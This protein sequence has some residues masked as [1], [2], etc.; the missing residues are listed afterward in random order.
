[1]TFEGQDR[2]SEHYRPAIDGLRAIA[3]IAVMIVHARPGLLPGG[4]AGV[5][6]FFVISGYLITRIV[7]REHAEAR[8]TLA[9]FYLNR[10]KRILPALSVVLAASLAG[11]VL[12]CD[13]AQARALG[14]NLAA[15][16]VFAGNIYSWLE[17]GGYFSIG[18]A[19]MP[20]AHLW[21]LAVEEQF[22]LLYPLLLLALVRLFPR[23]LWLV[24]TV[25]AASSLG[26]AEY[27]NDR[28]PAVAYYLLPT[29]AWELL[30]GYVL[31]TIE[32][33]GRKRS[34]PG[35][36]LGLILVASAFFLLDA[37]TPFPGLAGAP[38]VAET[39]MLIRWAT[40]ETLVGKALASAPLRGLGLL[41][42]SAFL[43]HQPLL[44][45]ARIYPMNAT[46]A[47]VELA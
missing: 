43:W 39:V 38:L 30:G 13:P 26:L 8:F 16:S 23:R 12:L 15:A 44:A 4:F 11:A 22:Y 36:V 5:D 2:R 41:S 46:P 35:A 40:P 24:L 34:Q 1:M 14:R 17:G 42:Y 32:A 28:M 6:I 33:N 7:L 19:Q 20:L 25:G 45:F 9:G 10:A 47:W 3:V 29:R 27:L 18:A 31:A 37:R 21:S